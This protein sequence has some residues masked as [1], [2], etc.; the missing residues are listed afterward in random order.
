MIDYLKCIGKNVARLNKSIRC[1]RKDHG[2]F[3]ISYTVVKLCNKELYSKLHKFKDIH[4][5]QRCFIVGTGPSLTLED[6][7]SLKGEYSIGVNTLYKFYNKTDWRANYYCVIDPNTYGAVGQ[8]LKKYHTDNLF[9]AGN[10]IKETDNSINKFS[11]ECSSFYRIPY[12]QYFDTPCDFSSDLSDEIYDGA[13]VVY[14]A[15]QIAVYMGFKEIYLLGVDCNYNKNIVLHNSDLGYGK[16]YKYNWTKQTGLTMIEGFKVAK[17][18]A[19]EH[20]IKIFNTTRGGMLEV[21]P[22]ADLDKVVR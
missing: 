7:E 18:Y 5:G 13:S 19:D 9:I 21:F 11:L 12:P 14:A 3:G 10:R 20:G 17:K 22:R 1:F 4:K 2:S 15:I 8:C 6:V 16:G